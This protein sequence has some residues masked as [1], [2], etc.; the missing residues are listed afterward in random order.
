MGSTASG[1][2]SLMARDIALAEKELDKA[3]MLLGRT[4][5][6]M[7]E[8]GTRIMDLHA[9]LLEMKRIVEVPQAE[10]ETKRVVRGRFSGSA[11]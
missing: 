9:S 6:A 3:L 5:R 4:Q 1:D 2:R 7:V 11:S 10:P 8:A